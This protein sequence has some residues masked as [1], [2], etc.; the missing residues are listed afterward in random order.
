MGEAIQG[1]TIELTA[2]DGHRLGAYLARPAG[3]PKAGLVVVQEIFGINR[4]IRAVTEGFAADGYLAIAPALFDRREHGLELGYEAEDVARGRELKA[5]TSW[6]EAAQDV[7]AAIEA[8]AEAGPVGVVGYCWGGSIA[9]L[10]ACRLP[11]AA[12]VGY[13]GGQVRELSGETP[14]CPVLLHFG[15]Q[16]AAIPLDDVDEVRR[17]HPEVPIHL[18]P[19]GHGFN[20]D[21]RGSYHAESAAL[22]RERSLAFLAEHLK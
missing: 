9:W 2:A 3:A 14:R 15:D 19:A 7:G 5:A 10:A 4:H 18:Y 12:A 8:A 1:E 13:Y 20:C 22:A 6:E 11:V 21:L 17:L 16:D